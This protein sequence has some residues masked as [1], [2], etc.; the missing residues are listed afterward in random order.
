MSQKY[1]PRR[2]L[3]AQAFLCT[4]RDLPYRIWIKLVL[5]VPLTG[6]ILKSCDFS[7]LFLYS[8]LYTFSDR[9]EISRT[10]S[11]RSEVSSIDMIMTWLQLFPHHL[12][13]FLGYSSRRSYFNSRRL[14]P[15]HDSGPSPV[16]FSLQF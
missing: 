11:T 10:P 4:S 7:C 2:P 12:G 8:T 1:R 16:T 6:I 3:Y 9:F 13:H 15:T 5:S 14:L